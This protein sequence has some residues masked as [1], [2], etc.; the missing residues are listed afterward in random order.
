MKKLEEVTLEA[1]SGFF[2]DPDNQGN[3]N[4]RPYLNEIFKV[5]RYEERFKNGEIGKTTQECPAHAGP[6]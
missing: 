2:S 5:A 1:L 6:C 3:R 4:K